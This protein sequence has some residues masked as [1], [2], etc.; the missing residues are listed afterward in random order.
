MRI[1]RYADP[2][3]QIRY[4]SQQADGSALEIEGDIFAQHSVSG[5]KASVAKLLA[6]VQP[7]AF[8]C[9]GLNYRRHAE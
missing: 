7:A 9:I 2:A 3:G 5:R 6:P 8:L 4:A 1:I